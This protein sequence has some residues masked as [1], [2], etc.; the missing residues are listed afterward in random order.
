[1]VHRPLAK[2]CLYAYDHIGVILVLSQ[3]NVC[4][5]EFIVLFVQLLNLKVSD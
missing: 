3:A 5:L 4:R 1:M 2:N